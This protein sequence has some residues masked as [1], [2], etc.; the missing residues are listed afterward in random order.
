VFVLILLYVM[1]C[2]VNITA[3]EVAS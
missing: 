3:A 2:Y 1:Q